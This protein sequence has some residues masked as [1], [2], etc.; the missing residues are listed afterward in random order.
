MPLKIR[1]G[2][3]A[4]PSAA[5]SR[6]LCACVR[7]SDPRRR[8][9][10]SPRVRGDNWKGN[11]LKKNLLV[12]RRRGEP[13]LIGPH[14]DAATR[15]TAEAVAT[16]RESDAV[17]KRREAIARLRR[18]HAYLADSLAEQYGALAA[19]PAHRMQKLEAALVALDADLPRL[20]GAG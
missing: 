20:V 6:F 14:T 13:E 17:H 3:L 1:R 9:A 7:F 12:F 16:A 15:A 2:A 4:V 19:A 11:Y 5:R 8:L 18:E 10:R